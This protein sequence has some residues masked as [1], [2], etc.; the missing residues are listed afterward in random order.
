MVAKTTS[1]KNSAADSDSRRSPHALVLEDYIPAYFTY[2][3]GKISA[4]AS[5]VYRPKFGVGI[6]DWRIMALLAGEPW[7]GA[8][9]ICNS[10][11]L[12]KAAVSRS[13]RDL[14]VSGLIE[15]RPDRS[16]QRRQIIA[17]TKKGIALHDRIVELAIARERALLAGLSERERRTLLAFLVRLEKAVRRAAANA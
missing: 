14:A 10:T 8:S 12:D 9:R 17:L 6:T 11:G 5:A 3:A 4:G 13:V 1:A 15:V 7:V 2:L 16:D